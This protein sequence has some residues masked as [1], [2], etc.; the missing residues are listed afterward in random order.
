VVYQWFALSHIRFIIREALIKLL[1][2]FLIVRI[3][4]LN[5]EID[6]EGLSGRCGDF[7]DGP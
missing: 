6:L 3:R 1:V 5:L 2:W 7:L 4:D